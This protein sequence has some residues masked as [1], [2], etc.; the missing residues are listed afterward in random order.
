MNS[1]E[2]KCDF[3]C[4]FKCDFKCDYFHSVTDDLVECRAA[5]LL[6]LQGGESGQVRKEAATVIVCKCR[7]LGS[8]SFIFARNFVIRY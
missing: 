2:L 5:G 4:D 8:P 3:M 1:Y 7:G 6:A